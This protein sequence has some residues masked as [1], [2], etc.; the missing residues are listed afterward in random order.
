MPRLLTSDAD[1][2][3]ALRRQL[4]QDHHPPATRIIE[5]LGLDEGSV[6]IDVAVVNGRL[7]GYEIKSDRDTLDR[8]REQA[9][10]YCSVF[11]EVV[12][13]AGK[14]HRA[15]AARAA[16]GETAVLVLEAAGVYHCPGSRRYGHGGGTTMSECAALRKGYGPAQGTGCGARCAEEPTASA[17]MTIGSTTTIG[18]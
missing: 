13:V 16:G 18:P 4:A 5:E 7:L 11:D 2:R 10:V 12:L 6:R 15:A 17:A 8:L 3:R 1:V 9:C 14:R